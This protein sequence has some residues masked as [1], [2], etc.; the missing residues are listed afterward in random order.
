MFRVNEKLKKG[1]PGHH[2]YKKSQVPPHHSSTISPQPTLQ[3]EKTSLHEKTL[4]YDYMTNPKRR[5]VPG[6]EG[7]ELLKLEGVQGRREKSKE[8]LSLP[9][10]RGAEGK[11]HLTGSLSQDG[12]SARKGEVR[13]WGDGWG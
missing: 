10:V 4:K 3:T 9:E 11:W 8:G 1:P 13:V 6:K 7:G 5:G 2:H 12:R